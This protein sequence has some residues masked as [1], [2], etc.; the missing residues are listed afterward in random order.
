GPDAATSNRRRK[1]GR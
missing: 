1:T